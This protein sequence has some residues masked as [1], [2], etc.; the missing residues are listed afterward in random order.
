[1]KFTTLRSSSMRELCA[2]D[3]LDELEFGLM[4]KSGK[5][6]HWGVNEKN[7]LLDMRID[8]F[9]M[10]NGATNTEVIFR[11]LC[12]SR[13]V[14]VD[15]LSFEERFN[16]K[17]CVL[18]IGD[19]GNVPAP[20]A[21]LIQPAVHLFLSGMN[22]LWVDVPAFISDGLRWIERGSSI[23]AGLLKRLSIEKV[24][25]L[26][27]GSGG[28]VFL[29]ALSRIPHLFGRTH[30]IYNIDLPKMQTIPFDLME[31][32]EQLR[33]RNLQLWFGFCDEEGVYDRWTDGMPLLVFDALSK[34]QA[35]LEG[36]RLRGRR[37]LRYDE[38]LI[39]DK[40][41]K[42]KFQ[43]V[44][45]IKLGLDKVFAFSN[46][47]LGSLHKFLELPPSATQADMGDGLAGEQI[48]PNLLALRQDRMPEVKAIR[49]L[50]TRPKEVRTSVADANRM[51]MHML[52]DGISAMVTAQRP[53]LP[54]VPAS[55][56]SSNSRD[57]PWSSE[58]PF[59]LENTVFGNRRRFSTSSSMTSFTRA[60]S[61]DTL[62]LTNGGADDRDAN[63]AIAKSALQIKDYSS[64]VRRLEAIG[65]SDL[66]KNMTAV[67]V[68][69]LEF[70]RMEDDDDDA[71]FFDKRDDGAG[72]Y[73]SQW[74]QW[75]AATK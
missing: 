58:N 74:A 40:L 10:D 8:V 37:F 65:F 5:K 66:E 9:N 47:L 41:N 43:H 61:N 23:I 53:A 29:M 17:P 35:R 60:A 7:A 6:L 2:K 51:R 62:A 30:F 22:V 54:S 13:A 71:S 69:S 33:T 56:S 44:S 72:S 20:W 12:H 38:V 24:S 45:R 67:R 21:Q 48:P 55:R 64:D 4:K 59:P 49:K 39:T 34:V 32:E 25:V 15:Y 70:N 3:A 36:E 73:E 27:C 26:A 14:T 31:I 57:R 75:R 28:G 19:V 50:R 68:A 46:E 42:P 11:S 16:T 63:D 52:T 18:V 1:M